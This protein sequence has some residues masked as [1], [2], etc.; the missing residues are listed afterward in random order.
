MKRSESYK[1][2]GEIFKLLADLT[3]NKDN[4]KIHTY[5]IKVMMSVDSKQVNECCQLSGV[6]SRLV[7]DK[8]T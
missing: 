7:I 8:E 4:I 6:D 5:I 1:P 2:T 3:Q